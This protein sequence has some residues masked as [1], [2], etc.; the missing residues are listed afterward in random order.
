MVENEHAVHLCDIDP[1]T[2]GRSLFFHSS[3]I[4]L[5]AFAVREE[6]LCAGVVVERVFSH[7]QIWKTSILLLDLEALDPRRRVHA[8]DASEALVENVR[9]ALHR[10]YRHRKNGIILVEMVGDLELDSS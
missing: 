3:H 2:E 5:S 10:L 1:G 7:C 4:L 9:M 6:S 8:P